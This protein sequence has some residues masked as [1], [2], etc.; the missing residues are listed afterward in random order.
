MSD[1]SR[2]AL[3]FS[4]GVD[5]WPAGALANVKPDQVKAELMVKSGH[6]RELP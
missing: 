3:F 5:P 1:K 4:P 2:D 6:G